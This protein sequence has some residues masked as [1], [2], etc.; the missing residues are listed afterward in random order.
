M[1][2][3]CMADFKKGDVVEKLQV[4]IMGEMSKPPLMTF[5]NL[6]SG[7]KRRFNERLNFYVRALPDEWEDVLQQDFNRVCQEDLFNEKF[8]AE[9]NVAGCLVG[10]DIIEIRD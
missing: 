8:K 2:P 3:F 1:P 7:D 4:V 5:R 9:N 6:T 10:S